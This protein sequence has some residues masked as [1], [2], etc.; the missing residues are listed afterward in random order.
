MEITIGIAA[1]L[2]YGVFD[3]CVSISFS[4]S[5]YIFDI[6]HI[7]VVYFICSSYCNKYSLQF[8]YKQE[9]NN[10]SLIHRIFNRYNLPNVLKCKRYNIDNLTILSSVRRIKNIKLYSFDVVDY[11]I[12]WCCDFRK[13]I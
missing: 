11:Y 5:I 12:D 10:Q 3:D 1:R 4:V 9:D 8:I 7:F 6:K 2:L 13:D